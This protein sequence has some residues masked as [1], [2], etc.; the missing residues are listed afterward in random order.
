[1]GLK[2]ELIDIVEHLDGDGE[3]LVSKFERHKNE[4]KNGAQVIV[5]EGQIACFVYRGKLADVL[6]PGSYSVDSENLPFLSTL[7]GWKYGFESPIK[8][9]V[10]F[11][12]TTR[13]VGLKWGTKQPIPKRDKELG[14]VR[15]RAFGSFVISVLDASVLLQQI[16]GSRE[17]IKIESLLDH[18][19][20][21]IS[22]RFA[23]VVGEAAELS[24]LDM[25]SQ[26]DEIADLTL[27]R[28]NPDLKDIGLKLNRIFV[29][30]ITL[31]DNVSEAIDKRGSVK[32]VGDLNDFDQYQRS[33]SLEKAAGSS[34]TVGEFVNLGAAIPL[35]Q[36]LVDSSSRTKSN[37]E[38]ELSE[39]ERLWELHQAGALNA[40]E[41]LAAKKKY[42]K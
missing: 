34:N 35:A 4:I 30:G 41:F 22:A 32:S 9:D 28:A 26:Y 21:S 40:E 20:S 1:M 10:Y 3:F 31:P 14:I 23:D 7:A 38:S 8:S 5:R 13:S 36:K 11:I 37:F 18:V 39:L 19:R 29:E 17:N 15:L 2:H 42:L 25:S 6:G 12:S 16:I 27:V 24:V 33:I